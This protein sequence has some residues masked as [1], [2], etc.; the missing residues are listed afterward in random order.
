MREQFTVD[1]LLL[2][3]WVESDIKEGMYRF[4]TK[5]VYKIRTRRNMFP[6]EV[7]LFKNNVLIMASYIPTVKF[8]KFKTRKIDARNL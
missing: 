4:Y 3:G 1:Y 6:L 8:W 2:N 7:E 5:G